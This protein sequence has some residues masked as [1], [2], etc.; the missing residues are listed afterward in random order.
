M[1]PWKLQPARILQNKQFLLTSQDKPAETKKE[2]NTGR[3]KNS[4]GGELLQ[5]SDGR[6]E[7]AAKVLVEW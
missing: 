5:V 7:H 3:I 6:C 2:K 1:V 4:Q